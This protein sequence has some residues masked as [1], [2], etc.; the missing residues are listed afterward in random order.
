MRKFLYFAEKNK[1]LHWDLKTA[2][3]FFLCILYFILVPSMV[4]GSSAIIRFKIQFY[5]FV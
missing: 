1:V 5:L 3:R 2:C 4:G